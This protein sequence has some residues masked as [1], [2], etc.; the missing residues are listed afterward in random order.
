MKIVVAVWTFFFN[1]RH[2]C[3]QHSNTDLL[4]MQFRLFLI[5]VER[6]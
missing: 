1:R 2:M 4:I 6:V 3:N 5:L